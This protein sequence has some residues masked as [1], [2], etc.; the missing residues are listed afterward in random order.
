MATIKI[1]TVVAI[2][3]MDSE[4]NQEQAAE[5]FA[6]ELKAQWEKDLKILRNEGHRVELEIG[7]VEWS[8]EPLDIEVTLS[9]AEVAEI[10]QEMGWNGKG[11]YSAISDA[12]SHKEYD[13]ASAYERR[14]ERE[15]LT[16]STQ[17]YNDVFLPNNADNFQ[18]SEEE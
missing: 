8:E 11:D 2:D 3:T 13:M 1:K 12:I 18:D 14:L 15:I 16:N 7:V 17:F 4:W 10:E 6:A 5:A 9:A